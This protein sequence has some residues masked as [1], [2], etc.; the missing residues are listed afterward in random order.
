MVI[1][2]GTQVYSQLPVKEDILFINQLC[3]SVLLYQSHGQRIVWII[4][5]LIHFIETKKCVTNV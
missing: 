5:Y 4:V 2:L 1:E 3:D